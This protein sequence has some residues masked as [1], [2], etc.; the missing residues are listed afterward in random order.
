MS[1]A[2]DAIV[3]GARCAGAPTAM[4][5]ARR[6][7]RV[8]L[9]DRA[10]FPSDTLS[11]HMIHPPGVAALARWGLLDRVTATG[12]PPVT[13]YSFD[14]GPFTLTGSPPP[15]DGTGVGYG[16]RRRVLDAVLVAAADE[17]GA[18]VRE[19]FHVDEVLIE[20]GTVVGVRGHGAGGPSVTER[21]RVVIGADGRSSHVASA[22]GAPEYRTKP[23]LQRGYYA[24]WSGLP[25]AGFETY[26]RPG[27]G[28]GT[29]PTNDGLTVVVVG[30]PRDEAQAFRADVEGNFLATLDLVPEFAERVRAG[31]REERFLCASV[32]NFFRR[33]YGP[34][35]ALVGDA[36][37]TEDPITAQG[38]SNAFRDAE[39]CAGALDDVLT[40]RRPFAEALSGYAAARD[41]RVSE[42]YEFTTQLA[43]LAP[44]PEDTARL[45]A[46]ASGDRAA[47]DRFAGVVAGTVPPHAFFAP[48]SEA[49]ARSGAP[50]LP[51]APAAS[52]ASGAVTVPARAA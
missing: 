8:L 49:P 24:Y 27:R 13:T 31:H 28:W 15:R 16:P 35:W 5:L 9:V 32:P 12:C 44:P 42:M 33:P 19:H 6:G 43:T 48:A 26:A 37:H 29:I 30:W 18:E 52:A 40:G 25:V 3:V 2:Y 51:D 21:A 14:F 1:T 34:G 20:D 7:H 36:G 17:A 10:A 50:E 23:R 41:A 39:L 22:V 4:L 45:L 47:M 38:I 11:T 46:A